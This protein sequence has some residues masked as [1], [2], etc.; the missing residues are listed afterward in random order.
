MRKTVEVCDTCQ[1]VTRP[2]AIYTVTG[3][4]KKR[5]GVLCTEHG[6]YLDRFLGATSEPPKRRRH[7][8]TGKLELTT[9][10]EIEKTKLAQNS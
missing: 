7:Y 10:E 3:R 5:R 6:A 1:D 9:L 2:V 8:S 4:G